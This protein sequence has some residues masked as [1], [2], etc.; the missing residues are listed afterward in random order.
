MST[1]S[2]FFLNGDHKLLL[3]LRLYFQGG[4]KYKFFPNRKFEHKKLCLAKCFDEFH[5]RLVRSNRFPIDMLLYV[6][7]YKSMEIYRKHSNQSEC[8]YETYLL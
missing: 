1:N 6:L 4:N 5:K 8:F 7:F 3:L 2:I